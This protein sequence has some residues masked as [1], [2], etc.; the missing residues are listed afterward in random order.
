MALKRSSLKKLKAKKNKQRHNFILLYLLT[1]NNNT[2]G[3]GDRK[4]K[5]GKISMGSF[6][7]SRRHK[8]D[9][10]AVVK[11]EMPVKKE[12]VVAVASPEVVETEKKPAKKPAVKKPKKDTEE[13]A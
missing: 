3:K 9:K 5:R 7:V 8:K 2:M 10:K 12:K 13:A 6:G 1:K 11:T 4:S